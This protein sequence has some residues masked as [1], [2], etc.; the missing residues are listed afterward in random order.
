MVSRFTNHARVA[1]GKWRRGRCA[2]EEETED[3]EAREKFARS[4][5][6]AMLN[7]MR[8]VDA[9]EGAWGDEKFNDGENARVF[10]GKVVAASKR[11]P[12][13]VGSKSRSRRSCARTESRLCFTDNTPPEKISI[14]IPLF[15]K[16]NHTHHRRVQVLRKRPP[17]PAH[18][19]EKDAKE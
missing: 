12:S 8:S 10:L 3:R 1:A 19:H 2:G 9:G 14:V 15:S 6:G 7:G 13:V 11:E 17:A 5:R 4:G 18:V 16:C